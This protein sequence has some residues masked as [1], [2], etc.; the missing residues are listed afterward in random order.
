[1][2][3]VTRRPVAAALAGAVAVLGLMVPAAAGAAEH[4]ASADPL[5]LAA[6][7]QRA[8][9]PSAEPGVASCTALVSTQAEAAN[10]KNVK[11]KGNSF[12]AA[13]APVGYTPGNLQSAYG[14]Q[15]GLQGMRQTVAIVV[16]YDDPTAAA[17]LATYR[18]QYGLA[19]C[20]TADGCFRQVDL[21]S[22]PVANAGWAQE[23][24]VDMDV[25]SAVCPN[26]HIL[27]V[28]AAGDDIPDLGTAVDTAV[29]DG[30][31]FVD[32]SY[33]TP[34]SASETTYDSYYTHP[35]VA[36]TAAAGDA[37]YGVS[38]PAASPDVTA[39]GGTVL[40]SSTSVA[41]GWTE[42]AW[43]GTGSGCSA[44]EPKPTWQTTTACTT[45]MDNDVSAVA[46]SASSQTPVAFY[47]SYQ[48]AGWAEA[49]GT[50]VSTAL[51]TGV[52]ALAG[53]PSAGSNPASYPYSYPQL[54][55]DVTSGSDGTCSVTADCT[56][57]T[58]YDGPT[59]LGTPAAVEPFTATGQVTGTIWGGPPGMCLD[60]TNGATTN[61]NKIQVWQCNGDTNSQVWTV[62]ANGT[63]QDHGKCLDNSHSGATAGNPVDLY[64]C[65][66]T[67]AQQ[68]R[69]TYPD[70]LQNPETGMCLTDPGGGSTTNG[71]QVV[72][73]TCAK[74]V[75][76]DWSLP[77][78]VPVSAGP[79]KSQAAP[80]LCIDTKNGATSASTSLWTFTCNGSSTQGW[81]I[82]ANE[83]IQLPG[84]KC[85]DVADDA[86]ANGSSLDLYP[87]AWTANERWIVRSDG[88]LYNPQAGRCIYLSDGST[89]IDTYLWI[90]ACSN[91][92][93][94]QWTLPAV[95][96]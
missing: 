47:D 72:I 74:A 89:N 18:S 73:G 91:E 12:N 5:A 49:G 44:Y 78:P 33:Y 69:P 96:S 92:A 39:V 28:E 88:S 46:A 83:T 85:I 80:T 68:W 16:A 43:S 31:D 29:S 14:L 32:N 84:S 11:V 38:Y 40:T 6:G 19:A 30:A 10:A 51:I 57:G 93:T 70:E 45:R 82:E 41:R 59:G 24:S 48:A 34:E 26:C 86:T 64:T 25:V 22:A 21:S 79:I 52:Y 65:N 54:L 76:Q 13:A 67:G 75:A 8:C 66:G 9:A 55:N 77:Y 2:D 7:V 95:T 61:G 50:S 35:G 81:T 37:G 60:D 56:A 4:P 3:A 58:G 27:L 62:A 90:Y 20:T 23:A 15:S 1:V 94:E 42:T 63:V 17:D 53:T 36:I 71:T 87:C